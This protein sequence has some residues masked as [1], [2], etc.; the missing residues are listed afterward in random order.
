[1]GM[2]AKMR[3]LAPAFILSVGV[4]FVLFMVISD[5]NVLEAIGGRTNNVGSVN[6]VDI[7]Y[8]EFVNAVDQQ[9]QNMK[10]QSGND[11]D[12]NQMPQI[13][14]QVWDA[15][16]SQRLVADEIENFGIS[17]SEDEIRDIILG[18][19]PPEF[20][21]QNFI[22]S[23]GNFNRQLYESAI[24]NPQNKE[25]LVQAEEL[26]RQQRL[27]EKL[28]SLLFASITVS[29]AEIKRKYIDQNINMNTQYALVDINLFPDSTINVTDEDLK[30]Y[31][32]KNLDQYE[33]I[34]QRKLKYVLFSDSPSDADSAGSKKILE[35]IATNFKEDTASFKYFVEIYSTQPYSMD[36][37]LV[38]SL[39]AEAVN[40]MLNSSPGTV[41]G[42]VPAPEGYVLYNYINSI[43]SNEMYAHASHILISGFESD[44]ANYREAMRIYNELQKGAG[45]NELAKEFS[46]DPGSA[47]KGGELGWFGKGMMVPEFEKAVFEGKPGEIQK[48]I[49]TS[50][51]Y[52]I[53]KVTG[54]TD[55]KFVVE[56]IVN[57]VSVSASTKEAIYSKA[58]DFA[59][60]AEK[61][62][63]E[64]EAKLVSYNILETQPFV[65]KAYS[66][67]GL[68]ANKRII[69]FAFNSDAGTVSEVFKVQ[70]GY[71]V[72]IVSEV[73]EAGVKPFDEVKDMI[74]TQVV[75]EK[76]F[77]K[78]KS[79][80]EDIK[81][82]VNND[83]ISAGNLNDKVKTGTTGTFTGSTGSVPA[84]GREFAYVEKAQDIELNKISDP[85]RG[86]RGYYLIKVLERSPF[87]STAF[88]VQRTNLRDQLLN[89]KKSSYFNLWLAEA[90]QEAEVV[91][92]R[93]LFFE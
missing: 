87:D 80:A 1:M 86:M 78:A 20:L 6:G 25:V 28:Q 35:N 46:K 7:T 89:E 90:K 43:S 31:Y 63:F 16:V 8:Q 17:V 75:R 92:N 37:L 39:S 91:D 82:K 48:P 69:E 47:A 29:D 58:N 74:K 15:L 93:H 30:E 72:C 24:F 83:L 52:H 2:M 10:M 76:K 42:P 65:E 84:L 11:I 14:D 34:P 54:K 61:N 5:S 59:Y 23:L 18:D 44:S 70:N 88:S 67:P 32:D 45:F 9:M 19:N 53:I 81:Q 41:I 27:N 3:S 49:K 79:I 4:L 55:K 33:I 38:S 62:G 68:G 51:G 40:Q 21:K 85:V 12:E 36:T 26:V 77:E 66:V 56:K 64:N 71:A 13:R 60:I 22:D 57:P 50:F 73:I